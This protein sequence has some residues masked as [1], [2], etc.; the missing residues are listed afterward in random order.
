MK[1]VAQTFEQHIT[2]NKEDIDDLNH[3][4][5]VRY[6]QWMEDVAK[7]HW[8]TNASDEIK[9]KY[10]WIVVRHEIDYKKQAFLGD[11]LTLR[12]FV[13]DHTH[14]T[15][16]RHIHILNKNTGDILIKAKSTWCLMDS[17]TKKPVKISEEMIRVFYDVE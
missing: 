5:N 2:V 17:E 6:V 11:E 3:V 8:L 10:F 1:L 15:S 16:K 14:V 13:A 4:N 12:T 7:A 9:K